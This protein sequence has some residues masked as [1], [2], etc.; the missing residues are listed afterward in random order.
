MMTVLLQKV[1]LW[2]GAF[3]FGSCS[4]VAILF[5]VIVDARSFKAFQVGD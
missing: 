1:R 2:A 5:F 3:I 4:L